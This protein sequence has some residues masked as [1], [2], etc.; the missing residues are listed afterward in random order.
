[1]DNSRTDNKTQ[2]S[3]AAPYPD[4]QEDQLVQAE[5]VLIRY[6]ESTLKVYERIV[7]DPDAYMRFKDILASARDKDVL[8]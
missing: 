3:I 7:A 8:T 6:V 1:M 4:L 2:I 5:D